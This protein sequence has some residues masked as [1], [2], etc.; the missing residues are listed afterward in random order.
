MREY[1]WLLG[2]ALAA[3]LAACGKS[4]D[5]RQEQ[6][7][8]LAADQ[9]WSQTADD[10]N[11][12]MS[13]FLPDASM[14]PFGMPIAKGQ[15]AIRATMAKLMAPGVSVSWKATKAEV[16]AAGDVGYTT[17]A[18]EATGP[19]GSDK[20]KYVTVWKKQANGTWKVA[21][22]IFNPDSTPESAPSPHVALE[23]SALKW[24]DAPPGLP[25]GAKVAVLSGDPSKAGPFAIR[26]KFPAGYKISPHWHPSDENITVISGTFALGMG[27]AFD[28]AAMQGLPA[29]GYSVLPAKMNHFA[30]AKTAA[31][32]QIT[33]MGPF[34]ITYVNP[35][36]DPRQA[37]K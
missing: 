37:A 30:M 2:M 24:G 12:F 31:V 5:V 27:D 16:A 33:G 19:A 1:R 18:Y 7:M 26:A 3:V 35:A 10:I 6:R 14:Y 28:Q 36:D 22:D 8:L 13:F 11:K 15:E 9:E 23:P 32:I 25:A 29:G 4:V 17:G 21:E 34:A 20:G